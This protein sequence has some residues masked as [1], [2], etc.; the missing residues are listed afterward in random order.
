M[1]KIIKISVILIICILLGIICCVLLSQETPELEIKR[2]DV[3]MKA[4]KTSQKMVEDTAY[5]YIETEKLDSQTFM[6]QKVNEYVDSIILNFKEENNLEVKNQYRAILT[7]NI[8]SFKVTEN[9]YGIRVTSMLKRNNSTEYDTLVKTFNYA[10]DSEDD[11][12]LNELFRKGYEDIISQDINK[13]FLLKEKSIMFYDGKIMVSQISYNTLKEY[14]KPNIFSASNLDIS[15]EEY[16]ELFSNI[17]DPNKKMVAITFDDGPHNVN[18]NKILE[19]LEKYNARATFFMLGQNISA[20]ADT[21]K[22]V[23]DNG[24]EIGI[25]TW[26][27][28]QLTKLSAENITKQVQ[29]TSDIIYDITGYRPK[30]VRPPYGAINS[31]VK[32]TL[33]DYSLILW[34]IDS[35]D[36]KSRDENKIVPLV[37]ENVQDGD[38]ILLHDIHSTTVPAAEKIIS[39]LVEQDYQLVTVSELLETKGYDLNTTQVF[40]SGR[41]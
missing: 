9:I 18:T 20:N 40:Y 7:N 8:D 1:K 41:Q 30:L 36:W 32:S 6:D 25:H 11:I 5:Y 19:A 14:V 22:K 23:Y 38:I 35:L 26:D 33:S 15:D 16:N 31:I 21:V 4:L 34:N 24:N 27:H 37:M 10:K 28:P 17:I 39:S 29:S 3:E 12:S 13:E 2:A